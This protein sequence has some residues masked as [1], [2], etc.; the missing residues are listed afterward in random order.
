MRLACILFTIAIA[1]AHLLDAPTAQAGEQRCTELGARCLCSEPLNGPETAYGGILSN[2]KF[3]PASSDD[4]SECWGR[5]GGGFQS[6]DSDGNQTMASV[7]T[8]GSAKYALRQGVGGG[9]YWLYGMKVDGH[10]AVAGDQTICWR[11]Y[12]QV[13]SDYGST[14]AY[15]GACGSGETWRNKIMSTGLRGQSVQ[16]EEGE[17]G[18][19]CRIGSSYPITLSVDNGPNSGNYYPLP[20]VGYDSCKSKPCRIE[21]CISGNIKNGTNIVYRAKVV[22]LSTGVESSVTSPTMTSL[23]GTTNDFVW[24]GDMFHTGGHG[25]SYVNYFIQ[26]QWNDANV[27]WIG[28]APEVEGAGSGTGGGAVAPPPPVLLP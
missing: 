22:P 11:Y 14:G 12:K 24:G 7:S 26:A 5:A 21:M 17:G 2:S 1:A 20:K 25:G 28:A 16:L 3:D 13:D 15:T 4:A 8:F 10:E 6:F 27:H 18:E 9:Y 23:S 19:T